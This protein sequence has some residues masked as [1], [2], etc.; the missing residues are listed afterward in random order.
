[1][2]YKPPSRTTARGA[3]PASK[4]ASRGESP[5][6]GARRGG[7]P[8]TAVASRATTAFH[9][10]VLLVVSVALL[11]FTLFT[12]SCSD[13]HVVTATSGDKLLAGT[14][15]AADLD[16]DGVPEHILVD[17]APA[18][19]TI[20]DGNLVYRSRDRWRLVEAGLGDTDRNG[21]L[22]VVTLLD[23]EE[24]RHLGL[25][26]YF[27]G[28]YRERLVT[29]ELFPRPL[30]FQVLALQTGN[31]LSLT[32]EPAQGQTGPQTVLCRW[33]GF[34]FTAV[35]PGAVEQTGPLP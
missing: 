14:T 24:G 21:L 28:E 23:D 3:R 7:A 32:L 34:G 9:A 12:G 17:G 2:G 15:Y 31:L 20:T 26:A 25:F 11:S 29:S 13:A 35:Q 16:G 5:R 10:T 18:S 6:Y 22:E 19:L 27:G 30:T 1:M 4:R 33:N 8:L